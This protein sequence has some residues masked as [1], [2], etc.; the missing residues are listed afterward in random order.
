MSYI[1]IGQPTTRVEGQEK[2]T[3]AL[4]YTAEVVRQDTGESHPLRECLVK[5]KRVRPQGTE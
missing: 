1:T 3:G 2:V 5:I 4:R